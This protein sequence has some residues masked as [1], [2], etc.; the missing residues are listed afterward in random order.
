M[1][2]D[3]AGGPIDIANSKKNASKTLKKNDKKKKIPA[4]STII[5]DKLKNQ[6][7]EFYEF[8][9]NEDQSLL[10]FDESDDDLEEEDYSPSDE[11]SDD[12]NQTTKTVSVKGMKGKVVVGKKKGTQEEDL[13]DILSTSE[14]EDDE[15]GSDAE[16]G[17]KFHKLPSK[18]EVDSDEDEVDENEEEEEVPESKKGKM[19]GI[20]VTS[21][22]ISH[23]SRALQE[24]PS[25]SLIKDVVCAFKA[26][27]KQ[28][29]H[30]T[31]V[32]KYRIEGSTV[33]NG[34]VRLCLAHM[35]PALHKVAG[36]PQT[37]DLQKPVIPNQQSKKWKAVK[38]DVK[39]YLSH[40][41]H[42]LG[43]MSE[44]AMLNV[45]LK[46]IHRLVAFYS[47]FP[48]LTKLMM[49]KMISLW[50][51]GE[52]TTRVLA[53][54]CLNKLVLISQKTLLEPCMKQMYM[55]YVKNTKFTSPTTIPLINF[56][57][58]SM[59][60]IFAVDPVQAY[61][62]AFIYIRQLAIHLRNA[63]TVK[64]K[65]NCQAVYNWQFVR[66]L[67][68][69][70]RL[71]SSS[72]PSE[73]LRP[74]IYP[75]TQTVIG[76]IKL[77]PTA[78]YYPLRFHL[79]RALNRLSQATDTFIPVL[80]LVLEVLEQ[81]DFNKRHKTVSLKPFNF[82]CMLKFSKAQLQEKAFKDGLIDQLYEILLDQLHIHASSIGFPELVLPGIIQ[83]RDFM[84]KCKIANYC[85]QIK[86]IVEKVD[87]NIRFINNRRKSTNIQLSDTK[88]VEA[89]GRECKE[90]GTPLGKFYSNWRKLRDRELQHQIAQKDLI[91]GVDE[92][93]RIERDRGPVKAS[94]EDKKEFSALFDEESDSDDETRF[95]PKNER[96]AKKQ[97]T[98]HGDSSDDSQDYSDFDSDELEILARSGDEDSDEDGEE[99]A[100]VADEVDDVDDEED[101]VEINDE[102][103]GSE[104]DE[105]GIQSSSDEQDDIDEKEDIVQN[106]ELSDSD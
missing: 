8:L 54:L 90:A 94:E 55:S 93:P 68:F 89:W 61:Q 31:E 85:K 24:K 63:I 102:D 58:M 42:L 33:F 104:E 13:D 11:S 38:L 30:E 49:K 99:D 3:D 51:K 71:L 101:D 9:K 46:H 96:P 83:L 12:E 44:S 64:K 105:G 26:A 6:D 92:M 67:E 75:L 21:K 19:K 41:L 17:G 48:K 74:L 73:A 97:K 57:Q 103:E 106:F 78:R 81:T 69:W 34:I 1:N 5:E 86:Q 82:A 16:T 91:V 62:H 15:E 20:L 87:E 53:F 29:G 4:K 43:E 10:N 39:T 36:V 45:I 2:V 7:P 100:E 84:K 60:E 14:D 28:A 18:L 66:C 35:S 52:E 27:V 56:M 80:P 40:L 76:T 77:I 22:M 23:W 25:S 72:H 32:N 79:I 47:V 65:E 59:V 95:L 98:S 37:T 88:A 70:V 50:S